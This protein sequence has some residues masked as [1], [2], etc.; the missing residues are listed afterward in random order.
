[1]LLQ[2][3]SIKDKLVPKNERLYTNFLCQNQ[4]ENL[5]AIKNAYSGS[6]YTLACKNVA[7]I[8]RL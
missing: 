2:F 6:E 3:F 4:L 5:I 8:T 1:M 7:C